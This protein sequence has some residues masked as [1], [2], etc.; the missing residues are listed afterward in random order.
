MPI[1]GLVIIMIGA[2]ALAV[3]AYV[4]E[5]PA[6]LSRHS[7]GVPSALVGIAMLFWL[8][9][10]ARTPCEVISN[11]VYVTKEM[12]NPDGSSFTIIVLEGDVLNI[13]KET[14]KSFPEGTS[15]R[16]TVT[17]NISGGVWWMSAG[18][19]KETVEYAVVP[20]ESDGL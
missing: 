14:G 12:S 18:Q 4:G 6:S 9:L 20:G 1:V 19:K 11:E 10:A 8:I 5:K 2:F 16:R 13:T 15:V 7:L 17:S 3:A